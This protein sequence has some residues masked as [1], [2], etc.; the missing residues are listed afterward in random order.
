LLDPSALDALKILTARLERTPELE[1][2]AAQALSKA[3]SGQIFQKMID[4]GLSYGQAF[5]GTL[6]FLS[7]PDGLEHLKTIKD[8]LG[9]QVRL[10]SGVINEWFSFGEHPPPHYPWRVTV[11][12]R[13]ARLFDEERA[14]LA[15]YSKHFTD[16]AD[17]AK[18]L[19]KLGI[20]PAQAHENRLRSSRAVTFLKIKVSGRTPVPDKLNADHFTFS[21][22]C[23]VCGAEK[24]R[25]DDH[26]PE[27]VPVRCSSCGIAFGM[28]S[29]IKSKA[30]QS[31]RITA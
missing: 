30:E 1:P 11:I 25:V 7:D 6:S 21:F 20:F 26:A 4:E 13:K 9:E 5:G 22:K 23:E 12:L 27:D 10:T 3:S 29:S 14:F 16:R 31:A 18:R 8:D 28:L 24:I 19:L 2:E 17:F 15:A